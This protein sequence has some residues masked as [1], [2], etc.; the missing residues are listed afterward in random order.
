MRRHSVHSG[1]LFDAYLQQDLLFF[2][3]HKSGELLN[4]LNAD[5][6]EFKHS[7]KAC[8]SQGLRAGTQTIGG[9]VSLF[10][11]SPPLTSVLVLT[12]PLMYAAGTFYG[13]YLRVLSE[14]ARRAGAPSRPLAHRSLLRPPSPPGP[15]V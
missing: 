13:R 7:V 5:V 12:L 1:K 11:L 15:A 2:D 9:L 6:Q 14:R 3:A 4:R 8:L 10:V